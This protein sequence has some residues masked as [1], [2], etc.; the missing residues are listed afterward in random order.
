MVTV[1]GMY[2]VSWL[3]GPLLLALV[4]VIAVYP[5]KTWLEGKRRSM[6]AAVLSLLVVI[7]GS[8]LA[9]TAFR[10]KPADVATQPA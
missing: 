7:F 3:V 9:L 6:W 4:I 5:I 2:W 10:P 8:L 1:A